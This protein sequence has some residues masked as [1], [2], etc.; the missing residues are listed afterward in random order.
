MRGSGVPTV[1]PLGPLAGVE[2]C[3]L[4]SLSPSGTRYHQ[5][6]VEMP[7]EHGC[8][9]MPA[10]VPLPIPRARRCRN[11]T[12]GARETPSSTAWSTGLLTTGP[13]LP[14]QCP[15]WSLRG[16]ATAMASMPCALRSARPLPVQELRPLR[17]SP[18]RQHP[19]EV[20][21]FLHPHR[22]PPH[23]PLLGA[24]GLGQSGSGT[25]GH[26]MPQPLGRQQFRPRGLASD[27]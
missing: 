3:G 4:G 19:Q 7:C 12:H 22:V 10:P 14:T 20:S 21:P 2:V 18:R 11:P 23:F 9:H 24:G 1:S 13:F 27:S 26:H 17:R 6:P 15:R 8:A 25:G 5:L 16:P